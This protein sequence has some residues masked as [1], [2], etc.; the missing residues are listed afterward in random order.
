[1]PEEW[2][3]G[4]DEED[5]EESV[6]GWKTRFQKKPKPKGEG[7]HYSVDGHKVTDVYLPPRWIPILQRIVNEN[8]I[9]SRSGL[10]GLMI[11]E[12]LVRE[13]GMDRE[14]LMV[15]LFPNGTHFRRYCSKQGHLLSDDNVYVWGGYR[16]CKTCRQEKEAERARQRRVRRVQDLERK[17]TASRPGSPEKGTE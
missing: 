16:Y 4:S 17:R 2:L 14:A 7:H 6:P 12:S 9:R 8:G 13:H 15:E 5:Y 11:L 10:I 1:M 3:Y